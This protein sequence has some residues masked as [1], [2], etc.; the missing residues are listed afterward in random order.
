MKTSNSFLITSFVLFLFTLFFTQCCSDDS[1]SV[2]QAVNNEQQDDRLCST[3]WLIVYA[4][5]EGQPV[6]NA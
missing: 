4:H 1:I 5:L 3:C 6:T 2:N